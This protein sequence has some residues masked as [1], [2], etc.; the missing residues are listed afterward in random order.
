MT[1]P[2]PSDRRFSRAAVIIAALVLAI[3]VAIFVTFNIA[4]YRAM[5]NEVQAG[6]TAVTKPPAGS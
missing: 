1:E 4:H 5:Q 3:V 2:R 6:N